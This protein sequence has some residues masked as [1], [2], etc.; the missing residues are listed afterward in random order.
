MMQRIL[1]G[2][3][4]LLLAFAPPALG[5]GKNSGGAMLVHTDDVHSWTNGVC[6]FFDAWVPQDY[7][8]LNTR[9]DNDENTPSLIWF[10]AAFHPT[11]TPGVSVVYFGHDHSMPEFYHNRWGYCGPAGTIE[12]P[13]GGWPDNPTTAGNSV[14]L[15]EPVLGD[16]LFPFYYFDVWGEPGWHYASGINPVGGYAGFV[17][18][19]NPPILDEISAF[20]RV[21]WHGDGGY[22]DEPSEPTSGACCF[23][24]ATCQFLQEPDCRDLGGVYGGDDIDCDPNPCG[25]CCYWYK[26]PNAT[27]ERRCV[28]TTEPDCYNEGTEGE[29]Q[30]YNFHKVDI[31]TELVGAWWTMA[32]TTCSDDPE[33][34]FYCFDPRTDTAACCSAD[35]TC[36]VLMWMNCRDAGQSWG[37]TIDCDPN[38]CPGGVEPT[39]VCCLPEP[40]YDVCSITTEADCPDGYEWSGDY[41]VC[42]PA[43]CQAVPTESTS[44]G[45]LKTLFR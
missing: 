32:G 2:G 7:A 29:D 3:L 10:I 38:P 28:V 21:E 11:A 9:T 39:G 25:V 13:D 15:G 8:A 14:A 36:E 12:I 41:D 35:G 20:G 37:Y 27:F 5:A 44:W 34:S 19:S 4:A 42:S 23:E 43:N 31:D 45:K 26:K 30:G 16:I 24:D 17:D 40:P 1:F 33:V 6:D 18:D 22:N